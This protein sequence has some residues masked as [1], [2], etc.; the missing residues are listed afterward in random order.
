M[1]SILATFAAICALCLCA[2]PTRSMVAGRHISGSAS[3]LP[4]DAEVEWIQTGNGAWAD[5]G[6]ETSLDAHFKIKFMSVVSTGDVIFGAYHADDQKDWRIFN[7]GGVTFYY[8]F[9]TGRDFARGG[10]YTNVWYSID[11][12]NYY[13]TNLVDGVELLRKTKI[14]SA[15]SDTT[16]KF[17]MSYNNQHQTITSVSRFAWCMIFLGDTLVRRIS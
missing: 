7:A 2:A 4:Y 5:T 9:A 11:I 16:Y 3:P 12:G 14:E 8:D 10:L 1:R 15:L 6:I 13:I 17:G